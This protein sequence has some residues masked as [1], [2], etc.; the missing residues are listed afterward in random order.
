[1]TANAEKK[2][3]IKT[4]CENCI[5]KVVVPG[6]NDQIGCQHKRISLYED[7]GAHVYK[8]GNHYIID[9]RLC[10]LLRTTNWSIG[11]MGE[12]LLETS[13]NEL[14][15]PCTFII[16]P[17]ENS[18][19]EDIKTTIVS[20]ATQRKIKPK[21]IYVVI[22]QD[23]VRAKHVV[24]MIKEDIQEDFEWKV[25]DIRTRNED[26]SRISREACIDEASRRVET[27]YMAVF[28][29]GFTIPDDFLLTIDHKFN[30]ELDQFLLLRPNESG[31][32]LF[33]QA[34]LYGLVMGYRPMRLRSY[35]DGELVGDN[36]VNKAEFF[37]D[38]QKLNRL[39]R[40]VEDVIPSMK[41]FTWI[42]KLKD[43]SKLTSADSS[44]TKS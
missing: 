7:K 39:I 3:S 15:V 31:S 6:T 19:L 11:H 42:R 16:L 1:M 43:E 36:L 38:E 10:T 5:F 29:A 9:D 35:K 4:S 27:Q 34:R 22:N 20:A 32:G 23:N 37:A 8:E 30:D 40:N 33:V 17:I 12:N 41:D 24:K 18:D 28:N 25:E 13:R 14:T 44:N 26:G 2:P 21:L